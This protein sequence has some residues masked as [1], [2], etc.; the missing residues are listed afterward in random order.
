MSSSGRYPPDGHTAILH[1]SCFKRNCP[2]S[3]KLGPCV[4][5]FRST[6]QCEHFIKNQIC[7]SLYRAKG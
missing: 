7:L 1:I 5:W 2:V 3:E 6:P 4:E